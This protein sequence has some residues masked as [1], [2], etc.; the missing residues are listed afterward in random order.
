MIQIP[1]K[2]GEISINRDKGVADF[3]STLMVARNIIHAQHLATTSFAKHMALNDL[4]DALPDHIDDLVEKWQGYNGRIFEGY[5]SGDGSA[6]G[7]GDPIKVVSTLLKY[8]ES[9]RTVFGQVSMLQNIVDELVADIA[10]ARYKL[11]FLS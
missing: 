4:Y 1:T 9:N 6:I 3:I 10:T 2:D 7:T 5:K 8:V 11:M